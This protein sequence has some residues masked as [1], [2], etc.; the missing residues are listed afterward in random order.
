MKA[1]NPKSFSVTIA[2]VVIDDIESGSTTVLE[3]LH[4]VLR[5]HFWNIQTNFGRVE[6]QVGKESCSCWHCHV[7][8]DSRGMICNYR[9]SLS[10]YKALRKLNAQ[11]Q[12]SMCLQGKTMLVSPI[13][14]SGFRLLMQR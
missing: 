4:N 1:V 6:C 12:R 5:D 7:H 8:H 3:Q 13:F 2:L 11:T 10:K 9:S 14:L